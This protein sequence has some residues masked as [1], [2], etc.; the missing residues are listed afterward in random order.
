MLFEHGEFN[1]GPMLFEQGEAVQATVC[2]DLFG[3]LVGNQCY[4]M[5]DGQPLKGE[6]RR[7]EMHPVCLNKY[8]HILTYIHI[9]YR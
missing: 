4:V 2:G 9:F 5:V 8:T 6:A 3:Q 1:C 7:R